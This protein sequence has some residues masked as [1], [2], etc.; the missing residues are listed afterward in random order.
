[1]SLGVSMRGLQLIKKYQWDLAT[2]AALAAVAALLGVFAHG[3][4]KPYSA[5]IAMAAPLIFT[6][7][8]LSLLTVVCTSPRSK[9]GKRLMRLLVD[10]AVMGLLVPMA[11]L[12]IETLV[13]PIAWYR[14][15]KVDQVVAWIASDQDQ[16]RLMAWSRLVTMP[17]ADKEAVARS[18]APLLVGTDAGARH[19]AELTL[20]VPLRQFSL[21]A[22][23]VLTADLKDYL[24]AR[25]ETKAAP[26]EA[27]LA[28][29]FAADFVG[30]NVGSIHKALDRDK[31]ALLPVGGL[32]ALFLALATE[33][34]IGPIYLRELALHGDATEQ[35]LAE[36]VIQMAAIRV[37]H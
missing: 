30:K 11:F 36:S 18:L 4:L 2:L 5:Q 16:A 26:S 21:T 13:A 22:L 10:L 3:L 17:R 32:E 37:S 1:M 6:I 35:P 34:T 14:G 25:A 24:V 29:E 7:A 20:N 31:R 33:P 8:V 12:K 23:T 28:G 9:W 19:S 15:A 27:R